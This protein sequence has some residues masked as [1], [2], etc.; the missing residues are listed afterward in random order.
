M[1]VNQTKTIRN[2]TWIIKECLN[3]WYEQSSF[4]NLSVTTPTSQLILQPF[5]RLTYLTDHSPALPLLHLCDS[6]FSNPSF[7]SSVS[8]ARHLRHMAS[9]PWYWG[10]PS[11]RKELEN[12]GSLVGVT[13]ASDLFHISQSSFPNA[14]KSI[15]IKYW[16]LVMR[17]VIN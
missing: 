12:F 5:R 3:N 16:C 13:K 7:A 17:L 2:I 8:L 10:L 9:R 6:S 14:K 11:I 15:S 4:S 1:Q